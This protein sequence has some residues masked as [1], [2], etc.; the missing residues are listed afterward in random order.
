MLEL[1]K[2][3]KEHPIDY[4]E[5]LSKKPYCIS[6]SEDEHCILF[7]YSQ[8]DSDFDNKLVREC[9]G[10]ILYKDDFSVACHPFHKFG[11]YGESYVPVIDWSTAEISEKLD[12]SLIKRWF[13]FRA[14]TWQWSTN[15]TIHACDAILAFDSNMNFGSLIT[16]TLDKMGIK[17]RDYENFQEKNTAMLFELCT[18]LNRVVVPHV[19]YKLY[20]LL[21]VENET[22]IELF[23]PP[24]NFPT[25]KFYSF[26]TLTE[27]IANSKLLP[28]NEEGYVV[29]D[30]YS[31]RLKVKSP[32]YV[33]VHHL[34]GEGEIC[35]R[36]IL[37]LI[38]INEDK[39]F[40]NYFPEY[41]EHF[42]NIS[43]K[44]AD[45]I[46]KLTDDIINYNRVKILLKTRKEKALWITNNCVN[47][48]LLFSLE[49]SKISTV[50][51][52]L[53]KVPSDKL[54]KLI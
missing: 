4:K 19:D 3:L 43:K 25:P 23:S 46:Y 29:N 2:F 42:E 24:D 13:N 53:D 26:K 18:P 14:N 12:G 7:K 15:G 33:A 5:I 27:T 40:L 1:Q 35:K 6:F 41:L 8:I 52:F 44:Y 17:L 22:G 36:R 11:N 54:L 28:F 49:D 31:N 50:K 21:T 37:D 48:A 10:I 16:I 39:E 34:K 30:I 47:S 51:E 9:R 38:R 32:A 45:Y 20:Y